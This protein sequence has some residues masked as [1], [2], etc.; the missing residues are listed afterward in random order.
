MP[1]ISKSRS[2][3]G[4]LFITIIIAT[5]LPLSATTVTIAADRNIATDNENI[6]LR[7]EIADEINKISDAK[8]TINR[9]DLVETDIKNASE[10]PS[11]EKT[12]PEKGSDKTDDSVRENSE[13]DYSTSHYKHELKFEHSNIN[14]HINSDD[15]LSQ[16]KIDI[17]ISD[18]KIA[19][20]KLL[21]E[22]AEDRRQHK[23]AFIDL[24]GSHAN[25]DISI[26][27]WVGNRYLDIEN[28][29]SKKG[30]T[31]MAALTDEAGPVYVL[32]EEDII[33]KNGEIKRLMSANIDYE[34]LDNCNSHYAPEQCKRKNVQLIEGYKK[35]GLVNIL[36]SVQG[37]LD[38]LEIDL[39]DSAKKLTA[40]RK[41]QLKR[42]LEEQR[43][44]LRSIIKEEKK[45]PAHKNKNGL[46]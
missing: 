32:F 6:T 34:Y 44:I 9:S 29:K 11:L 25:H 33:D 26:K 5:T 19:I 18:A 30:S 28:G 45:K 21:P 22:V 38:L 1:P 40:E 37:K 7:S 31:V 8:E 23:L 27:Y 3:V 16:E 24:H 17:I 10:T 36:F 35:E 4:K 42:K 41:A 12:S 20:N 13:K 46:L 2:Y 14:F 39:L 43:E 15:K